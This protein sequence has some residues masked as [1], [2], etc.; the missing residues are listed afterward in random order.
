MSVQLS[1]FT[2]A[3]LVKGLWVGESTQQVLQ[4]LKMS[5]V[6]D[7]FERVKARD[8]DQPEFHQAVWEVLGWH[9]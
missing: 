8:P 1:H 7:I 9:G 5:V 2:V 6:K 4:V 3:M